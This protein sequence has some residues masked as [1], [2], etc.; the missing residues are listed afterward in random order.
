VLEIFVLSFSL[1][2]FTHTHTH[3][4]VGTS[5]HPY[6]ESALRTSLRSKEVIRNI[7]PITAMNEEDENISRVLFLPLV[8][9]A[10]RD[11]ENVVKNAE[12]KE[13][14]GDTTLAVPPILSVRKHHVKATICESEDC[15]TTTT[16]RK[17]YL[18][19]LML[20]HMFRR[21]RLRHAWCRWQVF[22]MK[23]VKTVYSEE[24]AAILRCPKSQCLPFFTAE[25]RIVNHNKPRAVRYG[26]FELI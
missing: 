3:T 17:L 7:S 13:E 20:R 5:V 14:E 9:S 10:H 16:S 23:D 18:T 6:F 12:E 21:E 11:D 2:L 24:V 8:A 19:I 1:S 26:A 4:T 22:S 15:T 25:R